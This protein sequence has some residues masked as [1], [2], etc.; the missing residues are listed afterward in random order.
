MVDTC[1]PEL[2]SGVSWSSGVLIAQMVGICES[3]SIEIES[4]QKS[5]M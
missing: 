3:W 5:L 2:L 1:P 4:V